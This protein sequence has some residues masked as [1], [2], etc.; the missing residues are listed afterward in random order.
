LLQE[1]TGKASV[2]QLTRSEASNIITALSSPAG[3]GNGVHA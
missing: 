1:L 3:N 2:E